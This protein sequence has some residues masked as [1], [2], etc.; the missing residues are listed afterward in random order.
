MTYGVFIRQFLSLYAYQFHKKKKKRK[1]KSNFWLRSALDAIWALL[2][3]RHFLNQ[4]LLFF[5]SALLV[6]LKSHYSKTKYGVSQDITWA[7]GGKSSI[8]L[9]VWC[10]FIVARQPL[11]SFRFSPFSEVRQLRR[12]HRRRWNFNRPH[13]SLN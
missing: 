11:S 2:F 9:F 3:G 5:S 8:P 7:Y 4:I 10:A 12:C 1:K 6:S 13:A